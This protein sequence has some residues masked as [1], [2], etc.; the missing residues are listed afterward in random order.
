MDWS[1]ELVAEFLHLYEQQP[2]IW[3]SKHERHKQRNAIHDAWKE[4]EMKF[5]GN[6][7]LK[8]LKKKKDTLMATYRKLHTKVK[9]SMKMGSGADEVFKPDWFAY[10]QMAK[11]LQSVYSPRKT[12]SSEVSLN[13]YF[14]TQYISI[15]RQFAHIAIFC[16]LQ[17]I[18]L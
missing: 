2:I 18:F 13:I 5:S 12:K 9:S 16:F 3:N 14:L 8:D 10:E 4:I 11:F 15:F 7:P 6:Y 17:I 1:N